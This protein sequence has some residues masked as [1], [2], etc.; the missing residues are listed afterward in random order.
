MRVAHEP[1]RLN[2]TA[3]EPHTARRD[4]VLRAF[5]SQQVMLSSFLFSLTEDW[6]ITEEALQET[7]IFICNRWQDFTPGTNAGAWLRTVARMRCR[8]ILQ[9]R[10]RDATAP[11]ETLDATELV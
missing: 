2:D 8:E 4:D 5:L 10:K 1:Q 3:G 7:A 9:R 6:D 11:L